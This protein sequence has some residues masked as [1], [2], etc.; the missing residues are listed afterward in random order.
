[1]KVLLLILVSTLVTFLS[2][3]GAFRLYGRYLDH[4]DSEL[5]GKDYNSET[6]MQITRPTI[7]P[8]GGY[9]LCKNFRGK[10]LGKKFTSNLYGYRGPEFLPVKDPKLTRVVGIGDSVMMGWGVADEE[11]YMALLNND[12]EYEAINLGVGGLNAVQ[13]FFHLRDK[14]LTL[15]PDLIIIGYVG[16]DWEG[17]NISRDWW[18]FTSPSFFVNWVYHRLTGDTNADFRETKANLSSRPGDGLAAYKAMGWLL[19]KH[20][21]PCLVVMDSRYES[22]FVPHENMEKLVKNEMGCQTLN[23]MR[24]MRGLKGLS[25]QETTTRD[26]EHN[27]NYII[28][29]DGHPNEKWHAEVAKLIK[30]KLKELK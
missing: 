4:C 16:N 26:D 19:K 11:T 29:G 1:M 12:K 3:E 6:F 18:T 9:Y 25:V 10:L 28:G 27:R 7:N 2:V 24:E 8:H 15:K 23:L 5:Q 13:E 22:P 20:K 14:G 30:A 17:E 21:I